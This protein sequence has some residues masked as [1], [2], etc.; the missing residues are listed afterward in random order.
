MIKVLGLSL[1]GSLAA[2]TR[3]RLS[4]YVEPLRQRDIEMDIVGLLDNDY[5]KASF[6]GQSYPRHKV[7]GSYLRRLGELTGQ[8]RYDVAMVHVELFPLLPGIIESRLLR[9]PFVYDFDDAFF[10]KYRDQRFGLLSKVLKNKFDPIVARASA[11]TAGNRYLAEYAS[12]WNSKVSLL[13]TV[14]DVDRYQVRPSR[15]TDGVFTVGWI[16]SPSTS[17]YLSTL[18]EPLSRLAQGGPVRFVVVG[19][20][21]PFIEGV[22]V[23]EVPWSED[24]EIDLINTF[25]VGVMP[26]FDDE[27]A[28][29][30]CAFKLI[31]YM[32][33]GV[34]VVASAVGTNVDVVTPQ[35]GL[36]VKQ[37]DDWVAGLSLLRDQPVL[38]QQMGQVARRRVESDYSLQSA[39]PILAQ[40]IHQVAHTR[41]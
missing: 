41:P 33:C 4:Q 31:Q 37:A 22:D 13:P 38:R 30:K 5:L 21:A 28:R 24:T 23:Q 2:S 7:A 18:A 25:D 3:Y 15:P 17:V 20:K 19:G 12:R 32:A 29:G 26:L 34:P 9:I 10:L 6:Q 14:V 27:W 39:A 40:V 35:C 1:Y 16:G 8:G 11:V 36:L